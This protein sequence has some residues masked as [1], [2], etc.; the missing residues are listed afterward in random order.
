MNY[1]F[2]KFTMVINFLENC[3]QNWMKQCILN[4]HSIVTGILL[5]ISVMVVIIWE[6]T[7][8]NGDIE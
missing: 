8:W 1:H 4:M 5:K 3:V 2:E 6:K 7:N